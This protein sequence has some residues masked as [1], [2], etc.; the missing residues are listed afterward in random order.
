MT[1]K[2]EGIMI[3]KFAPLTNGHLTAFG[4]ALMKCNTLNVVVCIDHIHDP[5]DCPLTP[6]QRFNAVV[7][8]CARLSDRIKVSKLDCTSFPYA[9]EDDE[10]VSKYWAGVLHKEFPKV[11]TLFGSELYVEMMA[12]HWPDCMGISH[13][14]L[15]KDRKTTHISAT[16]VRNNPHQYWDFIP[17]S[18]KPYFTRNVLVLGAESCG[19]TTLTRE[20]ANIFHAPMVPEMYRSIYNG[21]A[22]DFIPDDL[23]DVAFA[24]WK[25]QGEASRTV[26]NRGL[27]LHDTCVGITRMYLEE[28]FPDAEKGVKA[29][30]DKFEAAEP[31]YD[32]ILFCDTNVSWVSDGTRTLGNEPDRKKMRDKA[33]S[34]AVLKAKHHGA[35]LVILPAD[36]QRLPA[37]LEEIRKVY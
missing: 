11:T 10:E 6:E 37:A 20:L 8:E 19:K 9:K 22:M 21:K 16:M 14:I 7:N 35:K 26:F 25:A 27:V 15:D 2:N 31:S 23:V 36:Y 32:V 5:E 29:A 33:Y 3:G 30:L 4:L 12:K 34:I 13:Q 24:Q 18:V 28:Y 17:G 1:V